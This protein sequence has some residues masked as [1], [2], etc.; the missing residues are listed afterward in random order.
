MGHIPPGVTDKHN[1]RPSVSNLADAVA[2]ALAQSQ[3]T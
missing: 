3:V 2:L 1:L